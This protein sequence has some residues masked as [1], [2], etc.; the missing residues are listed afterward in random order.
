MKATEIHKNT[1]R[2]AINWQPSGKK[3]ESPTDRYMKLLDQQ[4]V[5]CICTSSVNEGAIDAGPLLWFEQ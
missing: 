5:W 4:L 2:V 1:V 3:I